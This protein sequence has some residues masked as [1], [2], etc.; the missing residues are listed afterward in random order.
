VYRVPWLRLCTSVLFR[1]PV[2][3]LPDTRIFG[4]LV[5]PEYSGCPIGSTY[6]RVYVRLDV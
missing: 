2:L 4:G 1:E 3:G 6:V 5:L